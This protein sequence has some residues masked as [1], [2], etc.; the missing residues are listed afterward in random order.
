[1]SAFEQSQHELIQR[2]ML[3]EDALKHHINAAF[4]KALPQDV[5]KLLFEAI[6]IT[7]G[8]RDDEL[9][10]AADEPKPADEQPE[11]ENRE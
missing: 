1:M 6:L 4:R 8:A 10:R 11:T 5:E 2:F 3:R 7:I 9:A